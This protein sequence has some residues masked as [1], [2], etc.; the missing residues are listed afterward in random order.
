MIREGLHVCHNATIM[1]NTL[2]S[3]SSNTCSTI[4]HIT[5]QEHCVL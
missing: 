5:V 1:I 2:E 3:L 4:C